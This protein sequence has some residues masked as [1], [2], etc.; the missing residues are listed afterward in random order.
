MSRWDL[1]NKAYF[2]YNSLRSTGCNVIMLVRGDE[3]KK[4]AHKKAYTEDD[5]EEE[6]NDFG[7]WVS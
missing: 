5:L 7:E 1:K 4:Y 2:T 6:N 3:A